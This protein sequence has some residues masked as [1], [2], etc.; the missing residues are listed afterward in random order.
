MNSLLSANLTGARAASAGR[1]RC[2][3]EGLDPNHLHLGGWLYEAARS[4]RSQSRMRSQPH[5]RWPAKRDADQKA[6]ART[7]ERW[8][9]HSYL[10]RGPAV[11]DVVR[12]A[13]GLADNWAR[14]ARGATRRRTAL[15]AGYS[16][17]SR[18]D[19]LSYGRQFVRAE[20]CYLA[21]GARTALT[22][23]VTW[24]LAD[25]SR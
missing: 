20:S 17:V 4:T 13:G 14:F 24:K 21:F 5:D 18:S 9:R 2:R 1:T 19:P 12:P 8:S 23:P 15:T 7:F 6:D 16:E 10:N 22:L 11:Y 3:S 25:G